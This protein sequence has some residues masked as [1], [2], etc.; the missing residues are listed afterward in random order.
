M[1]DVDDDEELLLAELAELAPDDVAKVRAQAARIRGVVGIAAL[2]ASALAAIATVVAALLLSVVVGHAW[3]AIAMVV[4]AVVV[5][6][7]ALVVVGK[8]AKRLGNAQVR[9]A[10]ARARAARLTA[11]AGGGTSSVA[12]SPGERRE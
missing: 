10:L 9:R 11:G 3:V 2:H 7:G 12:V 5:P 6:I 4:P 8:Q 1:E